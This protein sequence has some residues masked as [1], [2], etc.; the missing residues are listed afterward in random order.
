MGEFR[1]K[2][3]MNG[4]EKEGLKEDARLL[5]AVNDEG[6]V[7]FHGLHSPLSVELWSFYQDNAIFYL[8]LNE[9][10]LPK[11]PNAKGEPPWLYLVVWW[12]RG[13]VCFW[14]RQQKTTEDL[15]YQSNA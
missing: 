7:V 10:S 1:H 5:R 4:C 13:L 11:S 14:H 15:Y 8:F 6:L 3:E 2:G 12:P 9:S